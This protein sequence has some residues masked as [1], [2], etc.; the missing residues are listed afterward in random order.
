MSS[1]SYQLNNHKMVA[2]MVLFFMNALRLCQ[3]YPIIMEIDGNDRQCLEMNIPDG[4]DSHLLFI[5]LNDGI[6]TEAEDWYVTQMNELSR[7]ES[8]QFLKDLEVS[9]QPK[10]V[11]D[12]T[13]DSRNKSKI[14]IHVQ[15]IASDS[16]RKNPTS[17]NMNLSYFRLTK[18]ENIAES[19]SSGKGWDITSGQYSICFNV[20]GRYGVRI[21]FEA[22]H[23]NEYITKY[24][25]RHILKK[26]HLSPLE[27]AFE[28]G[29]AMAH[30]VMD[31]MYYMEK[32]EVRMKVTA[33]GTNSRLKLFS[34]LSILILV[35]VT[36]LQIT[37]L[38][39]YFKKK[40][41]L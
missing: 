37:Y 10:A 17:K 36:Y 23:M 6:T 18:I 5:P 28:D 32:R 35:G 21:L 38:K 19:L 22:V 24:Q 39:S 34:Y 20:R 14:S 2:F 12:N 31:E 15:Q 25:K 30:S 27:E 13:R 29:I 8:S 3:A 1:R 4:D 11:K 40:K 16:S 26:E 33:M 41:V 9:N 7:H